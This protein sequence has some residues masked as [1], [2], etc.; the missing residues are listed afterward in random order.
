MAVKNAIDS[1]FNVHQSKAF[2]IFINSKIAGENIKQYVKSL[3][4]SLREQFKWCTLSPDHSTGFLTG[5]SA[6][7]PG[8]RELHYIQK[9]YIQ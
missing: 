4:Y 8:L 9:H 2:T 7:L 5:C 6:A 1:I 3:F